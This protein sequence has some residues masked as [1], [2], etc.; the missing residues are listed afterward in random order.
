MKILENLKNKILS[1]LVSKYG[2]IVSG[3]ISTAVGGAV[4]KSV[5]FAH[6]KIPPDAWSWIDSAWHHLPQ[7]YQVNLTPEA[8]GT[9]AG[10]AFYALL[11]EWLNR[12][13]A[14]GI[15]ATQEAANNV[16][17]ADQQIPVDGVAK[18]SGLTVKTV[19]KLA[20]KAAPNF[21]QYRG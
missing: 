16:L 6:D 17:P 11:Q 2:P 7:Q 1:G 3:S 5:E 10:L 4:T 9:F 21:R 14:K 18:D 12:R 15:E 20:H 8:I 19:Q 13:Q